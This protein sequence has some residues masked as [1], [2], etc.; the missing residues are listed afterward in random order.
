M[1][2]AFVV[3]RYGIEVNGGAELLCRTVAEHLSRYVS[4]EIITTCA[5]DYVTWNNEYPAGSSV[6]NNVKIH[7]FPVEFPRDIT[8]FNNFSDFIFKHD[9]TT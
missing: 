6:L 9:H 3:Q 2:I 5:I 1:K 8:K 7:R 4:I